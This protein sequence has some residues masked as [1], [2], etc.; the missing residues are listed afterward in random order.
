[1][2]QSTITQQDYGNRDILVLASTEKP[3]GKGKAFVNCVV[4]WKAFPELDLVD[5]KESVVNF[6]Q[7]ADQDRNSMS[8]QNLSCNCSTIISCAIVQV[9]SYE[10]VHTYFPRNRANHIC[11]WVWFCFLQGI[12]IVAAHIAT[13]IKTAPVKEKMSQ[14]LEEVIHLVSCKVTLT[15]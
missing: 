9:I 3:D 11:I 5:L 14:L 15:T 13:R 12:F 7:L 10:I 2:L 1:M 4:I 6:C 8:E